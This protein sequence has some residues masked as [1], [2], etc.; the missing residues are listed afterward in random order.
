MQSEKLVFNFGIVLAVDGWMQLSENQLEEMVMN[1][2]LKIGSHFTH[3]DFRNFGCIPEQE[4]QARKQ[5][6]EEKEDQLI[7]WV[8]INFLGCILGTKTMIDMVSFVLE[9]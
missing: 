1:E 5:E 4:E 8:C 6:R 3:S 7:A 9:M 2:N